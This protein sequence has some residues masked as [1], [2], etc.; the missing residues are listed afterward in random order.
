MSDVVVS[1]WGRW[2]G[3]GD[4]GAQ[5]KKPPELGAG[6]PVKALMGWDGL[7][8]L[9]PET[10]V[11][12][13][14]REFVARAHAESCGQCFPCRL[15]FTEMLGLL[16]ALCRGE[17]SAA[18]VDRIAL[19][20]E[21]I[22]TSSK[23]DI[24]RTSPRPV[25]DALEQRRDVFLAAAGS[26]QVRPV[27]TYA[28]TVTAPCIQ[29]CPSHV[30]VPR[31]VEQVRFGQTDAALDT[32][33][34][35][36]A[37]PGVVGRV[38][39]RLCEFNCRRE[40]QDAAIAIKPLKRFAADCERA[41]GAL[42]DSAPEQFNDARVAII[43]AGPAGQAC[44]YYLAQQGY[45]STIFE[46]LQ[47]PGGMAAVGIPDY[48]LPRRILRE[49]AQ[50]MERMGAEFRW[51]V[52]VGTDVTMED[53]HK[54]GFA[55][56]FLGVG[57]PNSMSMRCEGEEAGYEGFMHGIHF[58][59]AVADGER[60]L[61]GTKIGVVGG[62]NVAMDCVRTA[63]R[64]G[65][66]DVHILYRRT[67]AEMPADQ[68]EIDEAKEEGV[69]FDLLVLPVKI[70]ADDNN[71]VTGLECLK[72]ELGE[73]DDSG[74]RRPVPIEGSNFVL[75]CDAMVPA[76]GQRCDVS[77]VIG[78]EGVEIT[79]WGTLQVNELTG[80]SRKPTLFSGGDCVTGADTLIAALGAGKRA[81]KHIAQFLGRGDCVTDADE[82]L[83]H[84]C[85]RLRSHNPKGVPHPGTQQRLH[86]GQLDADFR[87][88]NFEEVDDV[89][90]PSE[91]FRE[92]S[93]CLRCYRIA[94]AA[95]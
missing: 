58:L 50:R 70:L 59:K 49:E 76:I 41:R 66:T 35:D 71:K 1:T 47:E 82:E 75:E 65:F 9:D 56:V 84:L 33:L 34:R 43:G 29:A 55:A 30:D 53:L 6:R 17:G 91:A 23:C 26:G 36:C 10:D 24:G 72:M 42:H 2:T 28:G 20:A 39:V 62:G 4:L 81:A 93:R 48:R 74:R 27:G 78:E 38:C 46:A 45:R 37:L 52:K 3:S 44:A 5:L 68:V 88:T 7:V 92:A 80:Q 79:R 63:L 18:D 60:P 32:V 54:E 67:E 77:A 31:Y 21:M 69:I 8:L 16:E 13:L 25:L 14:C 95:H 61:K 15:G 19:L 87:R 12:D 89:F 40:Q 51:G 94:L 86:A 83:Q 57:A 11:V 73:P 85:S 64:V 22:R 90:S